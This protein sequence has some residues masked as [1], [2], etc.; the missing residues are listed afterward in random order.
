VRFRSLCILAFCFYGGAAAYAGP[1]TGR[2]V[3]PDGRPVPGA[4]IILT[5][6]RT[7]VR[8]TV[9]DGRGQ[10]TLPAPDTGRYEVR[11]A[12]DGFRADVV[13]VDGGADLRDVGTVT[14]RVAAVSEAIV[15]SAA[16]VEIPLSQASSSVTVITAAEIAERQLHSVADALRSV[17]GFTVVNTGGYG[18]VTGVFPRG[19]E[20]DYTLVFVDGVQVNG[21]GGEFDFA[22]LSTANV[23]RIEVVRGPQ[24][25][26]FG[27]NAIG[28]VVRIV[29]RRGGRTSGSGEIAGGSFG[30]TRVSAAGSGSHGAWEW[31]GS[32]ERLASDGMTGRRSA[33]G[34][35]ITNDD[36]RRQSVSGSGGWHRD[37]GAALLADARFARDDRGFP[38]PFGT[39]PVGAY[40][41][42]DAVSRGE[43]DRWQ[44]A[45]SGTLPVSGRVRLHGHAGI[46]RVAG[47]FASG[48]GPSESSSRRLTA[49][50]Q[51][52]IAI[53]AG[54][55]LSAGADFL[56]ERAGSTF[57]T[58]ETFQE[59]PVKRRVAGYFAEARWSVRQRLFVTAGVRL[60][61]IHRDALES[62]PDP[63][64]PRPALPEESILST[65]PKISAAWFLRPG[66]G[67]F[68]KLR[69]AAGTGIRPPDGFETAFTDNPGLKPERSRSVE[70]GIDQAVA[71][72]QLLLEATAF[73]ND[74]DDLIVAVGSFL[75]SSRFRTDNISNARARGLELAGSGRTRLHDGSIDLSARVAYT[76]LDTE[77][78][79]V[80]GD[81]GAPPPFTVGDPLL[82]R[83]RHHVSLDLALHAGRLGL[84][85]TGGGRSRVLDVEPSLGTFGGL[86]DSPGYAVWNT[87]VSWR[88]FR[89]LD[90]FGRVE[91][92]FDRSYEEALG[93]PAL[94]RG[95][96][97]GL[98]VVTGR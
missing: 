77:V 30:T 78:L 35:D 29:T 64:S 65:N 20:S 69:A 41:G 34:L 72:G 67:T 11:V 90:V 6:E 10:F 88:L 24:S 33:S 91:N 63:F 92:V 9:T 16:Q 53:A 95:A 37:D 94:G 56:A 66:S 40:T 22:H 74:Y 8:T 38:G 44:S 15:V 48:F 39:N 86:F 13:T 61:D 75:E 96:H 45:I 93:F 14:M 32:A 85:I 59:I 36:Y 70:A 58:G 54:L 19:G 12:L 73:A 26:L 49:R 76:L 18:A 79:A 46:N 17:P 62:N 52:D 25:A 57:I 21:F 28:A 1:L 55:D 83:P 98:R 5:G 3:D 50:V 89:G 81:N 7:P 4:Q 68:T 80:D 2:V 82:R 60:D 42:I 47:A 87:G 71:G 51:S 27:S 31:G 23:E 43:Y 97:V 84:F